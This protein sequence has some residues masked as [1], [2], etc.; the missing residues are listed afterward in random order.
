[1]IKKLVK[2]GS[3]KTLPQPSSLMKFSKRVISLSHKSKGSCSRVR[4]LIFAQGSSLELYVV[5]NAL[6]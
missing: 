1:M 3:L 6:C 2:L 4:S 5:L